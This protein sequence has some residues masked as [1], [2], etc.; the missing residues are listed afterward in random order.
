MKTDDKKTVE[1]ECAGKYVEF[2]K[3][4]NKDWTVIMDGKFGVTELKKI[5]NVLEKANEDETQD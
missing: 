4:P 2:F 1:K 3:W 5:I